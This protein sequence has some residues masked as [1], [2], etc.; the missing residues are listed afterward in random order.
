MNNNKESL[1][2]TEKDCVLSK[3]KLIEELNAKVDHYKAKVFEANNETKLANK[4]VSELQNSNQSLKEKD[5]RRKEILINQEKAVEGLKESINSLRQ[6]LADQRTKV[7]SLEVTIKELEGQKLSLHQKL[8]I[9]AKKI[10]D[11]EKSS[12]RP[13]LVIT[14]LNSKKNEEAT[15][16]KFKEDYTR[17]LGG[18]GR[19]GFDSNE[20]KPKPYIPGTSTLNHESYGGFGKNG[21]VAGPVGGY[22]SARDKFSGMEANPDRISRSKHLE[23]SSTHDEYLPRARNDDMLEASAGAGSGFTSGLNRRHDSITMPAGGNYTGKYG[24]GANSSTKLTNSSV[25]NDKSDI[26]GS[27]GRPSEQEPMPRKKPDP[28]P[29]T[30]N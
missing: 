7:G 16:Y 21:S 20:Y 8:E 4:A 3:Q 5:R 12:I 13:K 23:V 6:E 19:F 10:E 22:T 27:L 11:D 17:G 24:I 29:I 1:L 30:F 28:Y 18:A 14:F 15:S 25:L 9:A 26:V 2:A